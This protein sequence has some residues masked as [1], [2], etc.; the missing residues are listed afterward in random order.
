MPL[1]EQGDDGVR[2]ASSPRTGA[3]RTRGAGPAATGVG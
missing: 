1:W 3:G 2:L